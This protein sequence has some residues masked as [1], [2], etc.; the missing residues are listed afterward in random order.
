MSTLSPTPRLKALVVAP[1]TAIF[2]QTVSLSAHAEVQ[3][4]GEADAIRI[5]ASDASLEEVLAALSAHYGLQSR[6]PPN[7]GHSVSGTFAGSLAEVLS[8]LLQGYNFVVETSAGGTRVVVYDLNAAPGT[9][10]NIVHNSPL[11]P[12]AN[13]S[14]PAA[15][16]LPPVR[17][18]DRTRSVRARR[19]PIGQ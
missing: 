14:R 13:P 3:V 8:R 12:S 18:M 10:I 7:L 17:R 16:S 5:E 4:S 1:L 15:S 9:G 19:P 2:L 11:K 6:Y